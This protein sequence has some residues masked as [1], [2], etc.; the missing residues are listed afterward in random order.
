[1]RESR[2]GIATVIPASLEAREVSQQAHHIL[3]TI[4]LPTG[5]RANIINV[6]LPPAGSAHGGATAEDACWA[7]LNEAVGNTSPGTPLL[8]VGDFNAHIHQGLS[9]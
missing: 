7:E 4:N 3:L 1:M 6:Y 2:G 5:D 9:S 8:V